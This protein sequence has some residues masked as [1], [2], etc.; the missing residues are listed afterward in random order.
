MRKSDLEDN[1]AFKQDKFRECKGWKTVASRGPTVEVQRMPV[2][3]GLKRLALS[4]RTSRS[5]G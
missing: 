4:D 1:S 2:C 5:S 3:V